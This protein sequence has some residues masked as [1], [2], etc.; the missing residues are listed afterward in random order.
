MRLEYS[1]GKNIP[2]PGFTTGLCLFKD[3]MQLYSFTQ[4]NFSLGMEA[5]IINEGI[6]NHIVYKLKKEYDLINKIIEILGMSFKVDIDDIRSFL[7]YKLKKLLIVNAREVIT[8]DPY[9]KIDKDIKKLDYTLKKSDI[10]VIATPHK[11][12]KNIKT[13]KPIIDIWNTNNKKKNI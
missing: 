8:T 13:K 10:L 11:L 6:V 4:N 5:M 2:S 9:V 12:Y 3:T 1:R 7:S